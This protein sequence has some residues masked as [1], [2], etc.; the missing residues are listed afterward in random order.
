MS[1]NVTLNLK[2]DAYTRKVLGVIKEKYG[3]ND[4]GQALDKLAHTYG[5]AYVEHE[6]SDEYVKK[7]LAIEEEHFRKYGHRAM[8]KKEM[9]ELF[10]K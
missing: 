8:S 1:N 7:I 9:D 3:L 2:V 4:M 6:A 10:G 5:D